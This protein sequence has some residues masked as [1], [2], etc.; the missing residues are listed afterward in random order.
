MVILNNGLIQ[1]SEVICNVT[2]SDDIEIIHNIN[3]AHFQ[4]FSNA[5]KYTATTFWVF[6]VKE[7][8]YGNWLYFLSPIQFIAKHTINLCIESKMSNLYIKWS[9]ND[10]RSDF[11]SMVFWIMNNLVASGCSYRLHE[12][13]H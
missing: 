5:D 10:F 2:N 9:G 12:C 11:V 13:C 3:L 7:Q 4:I 8:T 1:K 6:L